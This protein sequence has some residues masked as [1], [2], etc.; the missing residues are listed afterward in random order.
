MSGSVSPET[1]HSIPQRGNANNAA[2]AKTIIGTRK[3]VTI[4]K[5]QRS[6]HQEGQ[7]FLRLCFLSSF[8]GVVELIEDIFFAE[9]GG[10]LGTALPGGSSGATAATIATPDGHYSE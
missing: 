2:V 7:R 8:D 3:H 4:M 5:I 1:L 6:S 9:S 10:A